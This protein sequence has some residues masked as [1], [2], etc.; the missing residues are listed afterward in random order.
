MEYIHLIK[1]FPHLFSKSENVPFKFI[2]D[3]DRIRE[4]NSEYI[5]NINHLSHTPFVGILSD[6]PYYLVVRDLLRFPDNELKAVI[7]V[8]N[9]S[10]LEKF[11]GVVIAPVYENKLLLLRIFR[12]AIQEWQLEFPRGFGEYGATPEEQARNEIAEE[13][14]GK[15]TKL[16]PLGEMHSN[17]GLEYS[18]TY[19]FR[20][21]IESYG[22][23]QKEEGIKEIQEYSFPE[24]I[25][26]IQQGS[27]TDGFTLSTINKIVI[28][29]K[30]PFI[31]KL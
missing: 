5:N 14:N 12:S 16:I 25:T 24:I 9:K 2:T 20:A 15:I 31:I 4:W 11:H 28:N 26:L 29:L 30:H 3:P 21:E 27:I 18:T 19:L 1:K 13:I 6:D 17:S 23:G 8:I 7:R 22:F 10:E